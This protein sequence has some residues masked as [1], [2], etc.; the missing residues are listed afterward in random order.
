MFFISIISL[1]C[2][3]EERFELWSVDRSWREVGDS[4]LGDGGFNEVGNLWKMSFIKDL[5]AQ[6]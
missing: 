6:K 2:I 5:K 3:L 1:Q 4:L